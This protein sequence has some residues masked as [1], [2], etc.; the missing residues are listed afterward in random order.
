[1]AKLF[2]GKGKVDE[3]GKV[4]VDET[5]EDVAATAIENSRVFK[6][7]E[8][9]SLKD[10][11]NSVEGIYKGLLVK[12]GQGYNGENLVLAVFEQADKN[13]LTCVCGSQLIKFLQS[14]EPDRFLRV[15]R[16][17]TIIQKNGNKFA[18]YQFEFDSDLVLGDL[19]LIQ[20]N[21]LPEAKQVKQI[22]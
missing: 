1:M 8:N 13:Y 7:P 10:E 3:V 6:F 9:V 18:T 14:F 22:E 5:V 21:Q 11:G 20:V 2:G 12:S 4:A 16:D 19:E 15:T 17:K